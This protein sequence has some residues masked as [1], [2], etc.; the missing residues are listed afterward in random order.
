MLPLVVRNGYVLQTLGVGWLYAILA[1]SLQRSGDED[2]GD[3]TTLA[4]FSTAQTRVNDQF[5]ADIQLS[6]LVG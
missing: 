2:H 3:R 6:A 1:I 5:I 4:V